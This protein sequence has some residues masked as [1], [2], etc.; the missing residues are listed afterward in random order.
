MPM[1]DIWTGGCSRCPASPRQLRGR[2]RGPT[3]RAQGFALPLTLLVALLLLLSNLAMQTATLQL[4][5]RRNVVLELRRAEDDMVSAAHRLLGLLQERHPCLLELPLAQWA[6]QGLSCADALEQQALGL[7]HAGGQP[8]QLIAW[9]P[10]ASVQEAALLLE[11]PAAAGVPGRRGAFRVLLQRSGG[12][13][14]VQ[15]VR[16]L[17]LRG[18][19]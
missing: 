6:V 10:A 9:S 2:R 18:L 12:R 5:A 19:S 3:P 1:P 13:A 14:Q 11:R 7:S 15:G 17:G 4:R 8:W 16:F